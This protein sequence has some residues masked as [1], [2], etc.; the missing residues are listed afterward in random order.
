MDTEKKSQ[1]QLAIKIAGSAND[2]EREALLQWANSLLEIRKKDLP[3]R[4]KAKEAIQLTVS[5]KVVLPV[6]KLIGQEVKRLV[7]DERGTKSRIGLVGIA[8]GATVFGGQSAGIAALGTAIGVPLW[9]VLG[10][11][12]AFAGMLIEELSAKSEPINPDN[13]TSYNIIDPDKDKN[14]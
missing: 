13:K 1:R 11:G 6:V 5:S 10:A 2:S 7:W 14:I 3:T 9:V 12:G 8:I 4:D